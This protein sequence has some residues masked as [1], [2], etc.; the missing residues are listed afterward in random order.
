MAIYSRPTGVDA[1][2][3]SNGGVT[4]QVAGSS[5][6][7]RQRRVPRNIRTVSTSK[8]RNAFTHVRSQWRTVSASLQSEWN[9][10]SSLYP[11]TNSLG[12]VYTVP[13]TTLFTRLNKPLVDLGIPFVDQAEAPAVFPDPSIVLT[14]MEVTPVD[15]AFELS[16]L[17]VPADF[18]Y[19]I[20]ASNA[21]LSEP[22]NLD[23]IQVYQS[24]V[25]DEGED[26]NTNAGAGWES[27]FGDNQNVAGQFV[28]LALKQVYKPTGDLQ[29]LFR[30]VVE[31]GA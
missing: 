31:V 30:V 8:S 22:S 10:V 21:L 16:P 11:R 23:N 9:D 12:V 28:V 19:I 14:A 24:H 26:T 6:S 15:I 2:K 7:V 25:F 18:L 17:A 4:F 13:G 27:K 1:F 20:S 3:G 29:E 5:S